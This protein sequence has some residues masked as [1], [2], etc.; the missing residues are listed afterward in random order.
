MQRVGLHRW[1][2]L[3]LQLVRLPYLPQTANI[4]DKYFRYANFAEFAPRSL[5]AC[6]SAHVPL[7]TL[8]VILQKQYTGRTKSS[9]SRTHPARVVMKASARTQEPAQ[10]VLAWYWGDASAKEVKN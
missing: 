9:W 3:Q 4:F 5:M 6:G 10:V 7:L 8:Q 1:S 2:S